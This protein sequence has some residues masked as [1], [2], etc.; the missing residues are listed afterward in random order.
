M[1]RLKMRIRFQTFNEKMMRRIILI[2]LLSFIF[3]ENDFGQLY[4]NNLDAI[5]QE[6][7]KK[8]SLVRVHPPKEEL[9]SGKI[10]EKYPMY[11]IN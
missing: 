4:L 5:S 1:F 11:L 9:F 10:K 3:G 6:R 8:I 7:Q 2:L